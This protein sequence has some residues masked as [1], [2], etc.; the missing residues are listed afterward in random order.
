[1]SGT[2]VTALAWTLI[3]FAWQGAGVALAAGFV[4]AALKEARPTTRYAV[5]CGALGLMALLPP[6]TFA[7]MLRS[8]SI[9]PDSG[10]MAAVSS[11]VSSARPAP[12]VA[13][14]AHREP[15]DPIWIAWLVGLWLSGVV[16][17]G[18]RSAVGW[19]LAQR[20]K[21]RMVSPLLM[22]VL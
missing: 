1:M 14:S 22:R 19:A 3:H 13:I 8:P 17:L 5:W 2:A 15:A 6:I 16:I 7:V 12:A 11:A 10:A 20:L 4:C 18:A 21:T 9:V